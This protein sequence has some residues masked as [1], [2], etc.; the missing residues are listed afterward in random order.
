MV[1]QAM[2]C[3]IQSHANKDGCL[4]TKPLRQCGVERY[5][6]AIF[7]MKDDLLGNRPGA[8]DC[9]GVIATRHGCMLSKQW[10]KT[11]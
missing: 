8:F 9:T 11:H 10:L 6:A 3:P 2:A 5:E 7:K 1:A 4:V